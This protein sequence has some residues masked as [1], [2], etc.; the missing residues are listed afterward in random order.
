MYNHGFTGSKANSGAAQKIDS[1]VIINGGAIVSSRNIVKTPAE[2]LDRPLQ[3][4]SQVVDITG[5]DKALTAGTFAKM[6]AGSYVMR[7]VTTTLAGQ[8]N[9]TL[10]TG[11]SDFGRR[12]IPSNLTVRFT[13]LA[14]YSGLTGAATYTDYD[15]ALTD[16]AAAPTRAIPGE[17]TIKQHG[18]DPTNLDYGAKTD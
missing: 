1:G 3:T 18:G 2:I 10:L 7:R 13:K 9:T 17:F 14:T 4:G 5:V 12:S 11:A 16:D 8:A 15:Y 6:A